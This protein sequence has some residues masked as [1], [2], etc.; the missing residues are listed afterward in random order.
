MTGA[1][2]DMHAIDATALTPL[3]RLALGDNR[4]DVADWTFESFGHSLDE[5]FALPRS[6]VRFRGTARAAEQTVPW[7]LVLKIVNTARTPE[8]PSSPDNGERESLL[9]RSGVLASASTFAGPRCFGVTERASGAYWLWLEEVVD[10]IGHE[11][12]AERYMLAARHLA[13]FNASH[14]KG[15][16]AVSP[17]WLSRS[18]LREAVRETSPVVARL[19]DVLDNPVIAAAITPEAAA[20]L[21]ALLHRSETWL[22]ALDRLPQALCHWDAH[23]AN[24][25]SRTSGDGRVQTVAIDWANVGWGPLGADLWKLLSQTVNFFGLDAGA[26][27]ALDA[28]LFDHY[29]EGLRDAGW[30][31]DRHAVRFGYT[32][33]CALRLITRTAAAM[34]IVLDDRARAS[35]ERA[36]GQ[37]FD[38]LARRF[39]TT[40][41]YYLSL[42]D[43]A[44]RLS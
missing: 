23:R 4:L 44:A 7:T 27:P 42:A 21:L 6:I 30:Q 38:T 13:R 24:L 37:P 36:A 3:V 22:D 41:P 25:F 11:W 20:A 28:A 35:F 2:Q 16:T 12:P 39:A 31:G 40:L 10:D 8:D 15:R 5:V 9:Y 43:E 34:Q 26:L 29:I 32:A 19:S 1:E 33:A 14:M 18:P 17:P